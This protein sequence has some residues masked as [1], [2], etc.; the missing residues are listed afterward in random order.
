MIAYEVTVEVDEALVERYIAYVRNHHIPALLATGC[1]AHAELDRAN[2]T[3]FRQRYLAH[4]LGDLER[5]LE[6]HAP[7]LRRDYDDHF[8]TGTS[9]TREIWEELG[10]WD[11]PRHR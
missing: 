5:Y 4:T 6:E 3:R 11:P 1:F 2:E 9:L 10:R 8:P 7:A